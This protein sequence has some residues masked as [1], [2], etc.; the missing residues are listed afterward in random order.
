MYF[1]EYVS[2]GKRIKNNKFHNYDSSSEPRSTPT[3]YRLL[4]HSPHS[5]ISYTSFYTMM[6][7]SRPRYEYAFPHAHK[8][9]LRQTCASIVRKLS[10]LVRASRHINHIG[11]LISFFGNSFRTKCR[12]THTEKH[13]LTSNDEDATRPLLPPSELENKSHDV[14]RVSKWDRLRVYWTTFRAAILGI[15]R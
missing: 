11:R 2:C 7:I 13:A 1:A 4:S 10:C 15:I 5:D 3:T 8:T 12:N 6:P 9:L 14:K